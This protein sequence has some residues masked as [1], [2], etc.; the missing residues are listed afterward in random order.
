MTQTT[1]INN[2]LKKCV[3]AWNISSIKYISSLAQ[4]MYKG[5]SPL[6]LLK[7]KFKSKSFFGIHR[8]EY[9]RLLYIKTTQRGTQTLIHISWLIRCVSKR[10]VK[11]KIKKAEE[12]AD[13]LAE[14]DW[15]SK[16]GRPLCLETHS[17]WTDMKRWLPVPV[18][19]T[20]LPGKI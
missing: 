12:N 18:S 20:D 13:A 19:V 16:K 17:S 14:R 10:G 15:T 3:H 7:V 8:M 4:F 1:L 6:P 11:E 2:A 9:I 5:T